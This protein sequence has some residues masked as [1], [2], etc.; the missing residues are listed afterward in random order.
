ML[1]IL[2]RATPVIW[3]GDFAKTNNFISYWALLIN[4]TNI[5]IFGGSKKAKT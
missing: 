3:T 1:I 5:S 4:K 2:I